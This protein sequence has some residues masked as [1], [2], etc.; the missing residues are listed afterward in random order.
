[1]CDT[2]VALSNA[3]AD[4]SVI[5]AKNSDREPNEAQHLVLFPAQDYPAGSTL[6][7]TYITIPQVAHTYKIFLSKPFWIWGAEMGCNEFGV[8]IG[9]ESVFTKVPYE[10]KP[11]LI[12]MDLLRLAL[13]RTQT[14]KEALLLMTDLLKEYGQD[15]NCGFRNKFLYH[16][17]FL[18]SDWKEAWILETAG[19]EWAAKK[20][21]RI[22]SISNGITITN[23]WDL[24]SA[25]LIPYAI[26]R[27]WIK[28]T[29]E[30]N[31]QK[32]YSD[33][34]LTYFSDAKNR[35]SCTIGGLAENGSGITVRQVQKIMRSH[36]TSSDPIQPIDSSL[37]GNQVCMH[38]GFGPIRIDQTTGSFILQ[39][40][41]GGAHTIWATGG[42]A[43]CTAVF[44]PFWMDAGLPDMGPEPSGEFNEECLFWQHELLHR[45]T[46]QDYPNRIAMYSG[47]RDRIEKQFMH[48]EQKAQSLT[49]VE[50]LRFSQTCLDQAKRAEIEWIKSISGTAISHTNTFYYSQAW[51]RF[52][53]QAKF[54]KPKQD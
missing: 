29:D 2:M 14:A 28:K 7:C 20:V 36:G 8:A 26:Q 1:M 19:R 33:P 42:A 43:P 21:D 37:A 27:G 11:G 48:Q 54:P 25:G 9:N 12:G 51:K 6:K 44:K 22:G 4:G 24:F 40:K 31:F 3:T 41:P 10:K 5:F 35:Q 17:S 32:N 49:P 38:A 45:E 16:N 23:Q 46:I 15:G 34:L 53:Q 52:N 39:L 30:F 13:E 47:E 50:R 18:I